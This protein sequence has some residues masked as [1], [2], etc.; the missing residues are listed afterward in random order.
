MST[1]TAPDMHSDSSE[2]MAG[3]LRQRIRLDW[4]T[5]SWLAIF[6]IAL[7]TRFAG[8][9]DRV[10]SHDESLHTYYSFLLGQNGTFQHT[11]LMHGPIL[12]HINALM[13]ALFGAN[14]FTSRL[15]LFLAWGEGDPASTASQMV[16]GAFKP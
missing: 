15:P 10:M 9:G 4:Y 7:V 13:Y 6:V 12:F 2:S 8:L 1:I 14:D 5:L 11:P 3:W 16:I